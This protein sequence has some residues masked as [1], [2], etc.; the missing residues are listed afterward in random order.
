M[1]D[2]RGFKT[3]GNRG[4]EHKRETS[5]ATAGMRLP[6]IPME[7]VSVYPSVFTKDWICGL[8]MGA[9][10]AQAGNSD[11]RTVQLQ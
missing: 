8:L 7:V 3:I 2:R 5:V 9:G 4:L 1:V 10:P 11:M 6:R